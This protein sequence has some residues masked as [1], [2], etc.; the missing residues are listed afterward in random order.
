MSTIYPSLTYQQYPEVPTSVGIGRQKLSGVGSAKLP[1]S[2]SIDR[3]SNGSPISISS[4]ADATTYTELHTF[5]YGVL[6]EV[7]LWCSNPTAVDAYLTMSFES[8]ASPS[9]PVITN[10]IVEIS[11]QTGLNLVYPGIT[12]AGNSTGTSKLFLRASAASSLNASGFVVRSYPF[13]G[14]SSEVYG[15]FNADQGT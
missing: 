11:A 9:F 2:S 12:H 13:A 7:Y 1:F 5:S 4:S 8:A 6:E 3:I 15:Y 14:K 10:L